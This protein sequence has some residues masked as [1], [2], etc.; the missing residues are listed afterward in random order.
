MNTTTCSPYSGS[1]GYITALVIINIF[2]G[3]VVLFLVFNFF[4]NELFYSCSVMFIVMFIVIIC[5]C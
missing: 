3:V 5:D 2:L 4:L 1:G